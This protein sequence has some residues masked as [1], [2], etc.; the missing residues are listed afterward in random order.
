MSTTD[1]IIQI[2]PI[3][4]T[5]TPAAIPENK[6]RKK[7]SFIIICLIS[8]LVV[9]NLNQSKTGIYMTLSS[10]LICFNADTFIHH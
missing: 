5:G 9:I 1:T 2:K 3:I 8:R 4:P 10:L 7:C 6:L